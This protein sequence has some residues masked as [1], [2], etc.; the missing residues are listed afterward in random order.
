M[1]VVVVVEAVDGHCSSRSGRHR[2]RVGTG[3]GYVRDGECN[4]GRCRGRGGGGGDLYGRDILYW[5]IGIK[6]IF[7]KMLTLFWLKLV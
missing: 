5:Y 4:R 1:M 3:H 2:L 6:R 7:S